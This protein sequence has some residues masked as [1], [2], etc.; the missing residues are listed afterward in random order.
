MQAKFKR[1]HLNAKLPVHGRPG[2]AGLDL[3]APEDV[4]IP[5]HER[6]QIPLGFAMEIPSEYVALVWDRS[7]MAAKMGIHS[8]AGVI[9]STYRGE[10]KLVLYNTTNEPY[11]IN[12][13]DKVAQMVIQRHETV[14]FT[15]VDEL[16]ETERGEQG[17]LSSG[18]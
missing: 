11:Q 18:K 14:S 15:E 12:A 4:I 2:D 17:F 6:K 1:L 13:G 10:I 16:S 3:F 9:D 7:G 8:M 5:P